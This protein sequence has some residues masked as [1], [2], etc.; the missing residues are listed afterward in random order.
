MSESG[1]L[2]VKKVLNRAYLRQG[3]TI[4]A[5]KNDQESRQRKQRTLE[6]AFQSDTSRRMEA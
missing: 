1:S 5:E 4:P 6:M 2:N 3:G